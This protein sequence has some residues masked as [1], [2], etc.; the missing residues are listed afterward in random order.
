MPGVGHPLFAH[1]WSASVLPVKAMTLAVAVDRRR[2]GI[3]RIKLDGDLSSE[4]A[5]PLNTAVATA[6]SRRCRHLQLD[7][8]HVTIQDVDALFV[9][10]DLHRRAHAERC[11]ISLRHVSPSVR[12]LLDETL[13]PAL[14][15]IDDHAARA[16]QAAQHR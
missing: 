10:V 9:L 3:T 12:T 13:I 5:A 11:E 15:T 16:P 4:S 8:R 7:L 14:I 1:R 2:A 6:L